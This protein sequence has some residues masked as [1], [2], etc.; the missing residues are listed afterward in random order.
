MHLAQ[1]QYNKS[2]STTGIH[3]HGHKLGVD[4]AEVAVPGHL[5][6]PDVII[7]LVCLH[8]LAKDMAELT[9]PDH[10]PRHDDLRNERGG[11][12]RDGERKHIHIRN[13]WK[14]KLSMMVFII[15]FKK[16]SSSNNRAGC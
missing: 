14:C 7:A 3:N 5:G 16:S 2:S 11:G 8:R 6:D 12:D 4:G 15:T 1:G 13:N 10:L 9:G